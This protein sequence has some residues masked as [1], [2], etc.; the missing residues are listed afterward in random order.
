M[1]GIKPIF[2]VKIG[3]IQYWCSVVAQSHLTLAIAWTI[4][5]QAP[6]S[7]RFARQ[8]YWSV[9]PFPPPGDLP[10]PDQT[11]HSWSGK[12]ILDHWSTWEP[13]ISSITRVVIL[14]PKC[15]SQSTDQ[16]IIKEK[17]IQIC[18]YHSR[19]W[20]AISKLGKAMPKNV[21][22]TAQLHSSH[23]LVK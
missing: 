3:N 21:Q 19:L 12:W 8:E 18:D 6:L 5:L 17:K 2:G 15:V 4:A 9:L 10:D 23:T 13:I 7:M 1:P 20:T 22:T 16:G 14:D 11:C